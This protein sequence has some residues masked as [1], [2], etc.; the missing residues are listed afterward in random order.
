MSQNESK[1]YGYAWEWDQMKPTNPR[2]QWTA[3]LCLQGAYD[4]HIHNGP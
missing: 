1:W 2:L 3:I 4:I